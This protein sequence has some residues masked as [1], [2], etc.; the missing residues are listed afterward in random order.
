MTA[1]I[2]LLELEQERCLASGQPVSEALQ[3]AHRSA[4]ELIALMGDSLDLAKIEAGHLQLAP[5]TTEL[6]GFSRVS[7]VCSKPPR[8]RR[9]CI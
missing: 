9:V 1:I 5:Q 3:V 6:K 8:N 2:G 7:R 4:R